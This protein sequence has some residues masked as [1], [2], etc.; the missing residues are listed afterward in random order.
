MKKLIIFCLLVLG[1]AS[2]SQELYIMSHPAANLAKNRVELRNNL[3]GYDDFKYFHNSLEVNYGILGNLTMYNTVFYTTN[4]NYKLLGNYDIAFRYRF[5]QHDKT[6]YHLRSAWQTGIN[7]PL[8]PTVIKD[9]VVTYELHPGHTVTFVNYSGQNN[10]SQVSVPVIDFHSSD[11]LTYRNDLITTLLIHK[12]AAT[13]EM[14]W[15]MNIPENDFKFGNFFDWTLAFGYL[16]YPA[17]YSGYNDININLYIENKAYYF[18]KNKYKGVENP[19]SGGFR[20]DTYF[21]LQ[22]IFFSSIMAELSYKLPVHS[23]EYSVD[24]QGIK[25]PNALLFSLRYLFKI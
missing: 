17:E 5:F 19:N 9:D 8:N 23:N 10:A 14:G 7:I 4:S 24:V 2:F 25:R 16:A 22:T 1:Q 11:N 21:G 18:F 3:M 20:M 15:N 13:G 12:F 6:N